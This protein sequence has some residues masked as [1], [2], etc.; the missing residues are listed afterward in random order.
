M[1]GWVQNLFFQNTS[2]ILWARHRAGVPDRTTKSTDMVGI[3][4]CSFRN[5]RDQKGWSG[6]G[7]VSEHDT[8]QWKVHKG[9][10]S[11]PLRLRGCMW[12]RYI[13]ICPDLQMLKT[14]STDRTDQGSETELWVNLIMSLPNNTFQKLSDT[15]RSRKYSAFLRGISEA[16]WKDTTFLLAC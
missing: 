5:R 1:K 8:A 14:K 10:S 12:V 3:L 11:E 13:H 16:L 9:W 4:V 2:E 15:H 7:E 6:P